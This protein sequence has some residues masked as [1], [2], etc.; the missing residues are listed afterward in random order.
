MSTFI[1][2]ESLE[3]AKPC[4]A[5][6][7]KMKGDDHARFCASCT[8]HVYNLS[9]MTRLEAEALIRSKEGEICIR[10]MRRADGTVI[11]GDRSIGMKMVRRSFKWTATTVMLLLAPLLTLGTTL[12][13]AS[14]K[15][16]QICSSGLRNVQPFKAIMSAVSPTPPPVVMGEMVVMGRLAAPTPTPTSPSPSAN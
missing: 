10:M 7:D 5:D 2:L 12:L 16:K 11:T 3:I 15:T 13:A 6:W 8:K 14:P 4:R 9:D 1:P